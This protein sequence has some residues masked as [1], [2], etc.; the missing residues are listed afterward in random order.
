MAKCGK[1]EAEGANKLQYALQKTTGYRGPIP[2]GRTRAVFRPLSNHR[3]GTICLNSALYTALISKSVW[4]QTYRA[5][6]KTQPSNWVPKW[7]LSSVGSNPWKLIT[8][9][10]VCCC[11]TVLVRCRRK[12]ETLR[13]KDL[14]QDHQW[15]RVALEPCFPAGLPSQ[16][17]P[18]GTWPEAQMDQHQHV[19]S[20]K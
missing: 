13:V 12:N 15:E 20:S 8:W 6:L 14:T 4:H 18:S 16:C 1:K 19:Y 2:P 10:Q 3:W 5:P 7:V 17:S 11:L 9:L